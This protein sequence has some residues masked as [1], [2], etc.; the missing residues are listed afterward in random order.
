MNILAMEYAGYGL[1]NY[2][3]S[4]EENIK[5]DSKSI[6]GYV[7][8]ELSFSPEKIILCGRSIGCHFAISLSKYFPVHSLILI[9]P[10]SSIK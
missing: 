5:R 6:I 8:E 10:F 9:A 1:Y 2:E 7:I 3:S 4:N